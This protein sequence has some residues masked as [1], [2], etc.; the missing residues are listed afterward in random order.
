[1]TGS[2]GGVRMT[3]LGGSDGTGVASAEKIIFGAKLEMSS[4][5]LVEF[6]SFSY[7]DFS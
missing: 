7:F 2:C 5:Y 6:T 4:P 1:M 3:V